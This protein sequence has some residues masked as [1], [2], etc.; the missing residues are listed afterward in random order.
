MDKWDI[1]M[2]ANIQAFRSAIGFYAAAENYA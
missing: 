1:E 2:L